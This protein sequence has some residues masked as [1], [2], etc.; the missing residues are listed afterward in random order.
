MTSIAFG[1][2]RVTDDKG[3]PFVRK[4][5]KATGLSESAGPPNR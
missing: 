1:Y 3:K 4:G 2:R 5:R